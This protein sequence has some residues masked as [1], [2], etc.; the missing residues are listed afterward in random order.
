MI[1]L[2]SHGWNLW[3]ARMCLAVWQGGLLALLAY[4]VTRLVPTLSPR[5]RTALWWCVSAKFLVTLL[6]TTPVRLG[7]LPVTGSA[8]V[9]PGSASLLANVPPSQSTI[10]SLMPSSQAAFPWAGLVWAVWF[11]GFLFLV[12]RLIR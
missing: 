10:V 4:G 12:Q 8:T 7:L 11:V 9:V 5:T 2:A 1:D 6:A 3:M